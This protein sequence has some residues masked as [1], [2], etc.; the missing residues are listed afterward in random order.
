[1]GDP[2]LGP[3]ASAHVVATFPPAVCP[4]RARRG[5]TSTRRHE[6][7]SARVPVIKWESPPP[8]R[9]GLRNRPAGLL[10]SHE[11]QA[12]QPSRSGPGGWARSGGC[13]RP[14]TCGGRHRTSGNLSGSPSPPCW[15][16]LITR[17]P[18]ESLR[19][20]DRR[21]SGH[22]SALA[23]RTLVTHGEFQVDVCLHDADGTAPR[24][25][26]TTER[27][28]SSPTR[29][30]LHGHDGAHGLAPW[31]RDIIRANEAQVDAST[32]RTFR[33][34][35]ARRSA[36]PHRLSACPKHRTSRGELVRAGGRC[37]R[38]RDSR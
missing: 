10:F 34:R 16:R 5:H 38:G 26:A 28:I 27:L 19:Q 4:R 7:V 17:S 20:L 9:L 12:D 31:H 8:T 32:C 3:H 37:I 25:P 6:C 21:A 35:L 11:R 1:M 30:R 14:P 23:P 2:A 29:R 18:W 33:Q 24:G 13:C 15:R 22:R 36:P